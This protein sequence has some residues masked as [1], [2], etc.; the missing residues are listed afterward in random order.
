MVCLEAYVNSFDPEIREDK[1]TLPI[2]N[3]T[4]EALNSHLN[5]ERYSKDKGQVISS[6]PVSR[7]MFYRSSEQVA[8]TVF[9]GEVIARQHGKPAS[10]LRALTEFSRRTLKR[11]RAEIVCIDLRVAVLR[12]YHF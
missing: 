4:P 6:L 12:R 1:I 11:T 8:A 5:I 7:E 2:L 9:R 10:G 3:L